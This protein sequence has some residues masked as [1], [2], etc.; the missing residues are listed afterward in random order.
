MPGVR[1]SLTFG[2]A[3]GM[4][5]LTPPAVIALR[6]GRPALRRALL[7]AAAAELAADKHPAVPDRRSAPALAG[8]IASGA[9]SGWVAG[10]PPGTVAGAT[11]AAVATFAASA[12]RRRIAAAMGLPDPL[13][14]VAED[15]A[16]VALSLAAVRAA[17]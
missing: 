16:A 17:H 4:R 7:V 15:L 10:G 12:L 1:A 11:G 2:V 9:G 3:A 8:R 6:R 14:A 13:V 5:S